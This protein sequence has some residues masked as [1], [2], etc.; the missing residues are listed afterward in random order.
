MPA[1]SAALAT[2][3]L[4]IEREPAH[5]AV[6]LHAVLVQRARDR[7]DVAAMEIEQPDEP[8]AQRV[9][10]LDLRGWRLRASQQKIATPIA[11]PSGARDRDS[12]PRAVDTARCPR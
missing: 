2:Q 12:S 9:E 3:R 5:P 10:A 7:G 6:D 11:R 1:P 4:Q 8:G